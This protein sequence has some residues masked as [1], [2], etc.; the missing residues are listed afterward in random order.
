MKKT[1]PLYFL[2]SILLIVSC[3]QNVPTFIKGNL[4]NINDTSITIEIGKNPITGLEPFN[5]QKVHKL[6]KNGTFS[7]PIETSFPVHAVLYSENYVFFS[8]VLLLRSGEITMNA[9]CRDIPNTLKYSGAGAGLNTFNYDLEKY[10]AVVNKE[11]G[12][13]AGTISSY[14]KSLDSI[15]AIMLAMLNDFHNEESLSNDELLWL[16]SKINYGKYY[17]L[18]NRAFQLDLEITDSGSQIFQ[19]LNLKDHKASMISR[20]Y[21]ELILRYILYEVNSKG[22]NYSDYSDN[23]EYFRGFFEIINE[24]LNGKVRD[25]ALTILIS[26]MLKNYNDLAEE[27]Y[28]YYLVDCKSSDMVEKTT[29]LYQ[30]YS[31]I[32]HQP[33]SDDVHIIATNQQKP[34]EVLTQFGNKVILIDFWASWCSPCIKGFPRTKKLAEDYENQS[35]EVLYV[36]NKD[37][38][39]S[40]IN[41]IKE[42]QLYG[43]HIILNEEESDIWRREFEISGIPTYILID[44][45]GKIVNMDNP[46]KITDETYLLIDSLLSVL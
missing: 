46:H 39:S 6:S 45:E 34:M 42:Y 20:T 12:K 37:Q 7:I 24:K 30:K 38:K 3:S 26:D 44:Q 31:D 15:Q 18:L 8:R 1:L 27:Y 10:E 33:L 17:D 9:D 5:Y 14:E 16:S 23:S 43:D 41:A 25:V 11:L 22:L 21:N 36:G 32:V 28:K 29:E 4:T 35:V 2:G 19:T 13:N 40:L